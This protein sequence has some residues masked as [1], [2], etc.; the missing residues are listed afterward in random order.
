MQTLETIN[1][2]LAPLNLAH[3]T[4]AFTGSPSVDHYVLVPDFDTSM[5]ADNTDYIQESHVNIEF[6]IAG[7]YRT[8]VAN[9]RAYLKAAG[10]SV[11]DGQYVEFEPE[12]SK[13]H[14]FLSI[15]D[16]A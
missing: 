12:T 4:G 3:G 10:L 9:A 5:S 1:T 15:I 7:E 16:R 6:Y 13:H 2:A 8:I 14:Y 11:M